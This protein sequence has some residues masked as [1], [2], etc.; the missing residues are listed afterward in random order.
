MAREKDPF[1]INGWFLQEKRELIA[2]IAQNGTA[3]EP[4]VNGPVLNP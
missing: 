2:G 4:V 3:G 1:C